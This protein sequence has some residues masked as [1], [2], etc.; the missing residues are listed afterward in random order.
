[1]GIFLTAF[2]EKSKIVISSDESDL[3]VAD[4]DPP[5]VCTSLSSLFLF[6]SFFFLF[7][8]PIY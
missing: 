2:T 7:S 3:E 5:E 8:F 1:M 4:D 6:L